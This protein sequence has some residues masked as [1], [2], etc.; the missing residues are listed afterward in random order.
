MKNIKCKTC[1]FYS[2]DVW[3]GETY[4]PVFRKIVSLK[5]SLHCKNKK[6]KMRK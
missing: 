2:V 3:T 6:K 4:C 1:T 5:E